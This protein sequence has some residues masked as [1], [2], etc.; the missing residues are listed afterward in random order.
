MHILRMIWLPCRYVLLLQLQELFCTRNLPASWNDL[1]PERVHI[2]APKNTYVHAQKV[3]CLKGRGISRSLVEREFSWNGHERHNFSLYLINDFYQVHIY[4]Y[5]KYK[6]IY[7]ENPVSIMYLCHCFPER[8]IPQ[9]C[10]DRTSALQIRAV[11]HTARKR[12]QK[13]HSEKVTRAGSRY[14]TQSRLSIK[15]VRFHPIVSLVKSFP[16]WGPAAS[17]SHSKNV[18]LKVSP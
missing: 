17:P 2:N 5:M 4:T 9:C 3:I 14:G 15:R 13:L 11:C 12:E 8:R 18:S 7:R 6:Y 16:R 10:L 1:F